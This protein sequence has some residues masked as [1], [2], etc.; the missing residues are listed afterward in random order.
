MRRFFKLSR[1]VHNDRGGQAMIVIAIVMFT[2]VCFL[3]FTVNVGHRI[4]GKVEL[5]NA[6]DASVQSGAIWNARGLNMISILNVGMTECLALVIM[7]RAFHK[8]WQTT[9][10]KVVIACNRAA[11]N[12]C[13]AIPIVGPAIASAWNALITIAEFAERAIGPAAKAMNRLAKK[14]GALWKLMDTLETMERGIQYA[15]PVIALY[16]S[17]RIA[18]FNNADGVIDFSLKGEN[19]EAFHAILLPLPIPDGSGTAPMIKEGS[20][21]DICEHTVG[22]G[23]HGYEEYLKWKAWFSGQYNALGMDI[24]MMHIDFLGGP[25]I[26]D[27]FATIYGTVCIGIIPNPGIVYKVYVKVFADSICGGSTSFDAP[28]TVERNTTSCS[29]CDPGKHDITDKKWLR[30]TCEINSSNLK[31][32]NCDK[33][34]A[35]ISNAKSPS[36]GAYEKVKTV[37]HVM[38]E[39]PCKKCIL[40]KWEKEIRNAEG[41]VVDI[42]KKYYKTVKTLRWCKYKEKVDEGIT[43]PSK[44]PKPLMLAD[45]WQDY[46]KYTVV[47]KKDVGDRVSIVSADSGGHNA[48]SGFALATAQAEVYNPTEAHLFNQ[49]WQA[50]LKPWKAGDVNL[51][52]GG[53][54]DLPSVIQKAVNEGAKEVIVH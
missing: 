3:V 47:V 30:E 44:K 36:D 27:I 14:N 31:A 42:K 9:L 17:D 25:S 2:I 8:T 34:N 13:S 33:S 4:T 49:D 10:N 40:K 41:E 12:A 52:I 38:S 54:N 53:L 7:F 29:E 37:T 45:D 18:A 46:A 50:N 48:I 43:P 28:E 5:Q 21:D 6:A 15:A 11:A 20:F 16:E 23:G 39:D 26:Q 35:C 51:G 24:P 1:D 22:D 19:V 32:Y